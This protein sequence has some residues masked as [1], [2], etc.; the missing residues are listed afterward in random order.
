M[1]AEPVVLGDQHVAQLRVLQASAHLLPDELRD[2]LA[3]L[4]VEEHL[5][6]PGQPELQ[7]AV[8][9]DLLQHVPP[10]EWGQVGPDVLEVVLE[11]GEGVGQGLALA[12]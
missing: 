3:D 10:L 5:G 6:E 4:L 9:V 11:A 1:G 8:L 7:R 12:R 2:L